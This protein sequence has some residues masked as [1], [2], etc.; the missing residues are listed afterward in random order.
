MPRNRRIEISGGVYHVITRGIERC[1]IFKDDHDHEE[2]VKRLEAALKDTGHKCYGWALMPNH[3]HLLIGTGV[4]PLSELMRKLLTGYAVYFN[5]KHKRSGHLYQNRYKS[6]LCQEESYLLE[7]V[8]YIHLNPLRAKLVTDMAGLGRYQWSGYTALVG[9]RSNAWQSTGEILERFGNKR[10]TAIR[11]FE[12]FV[13]DG[14]S[15]GKRTDLTGG[16]LRRSAGGWRGVYELKR[17]KERWQGDERVLGDGDFVAKVLST[18]EEKIERKERLKRDGWDIE[19]LKEEV[20]RIMKVSK[21]A[22][23]KRSRLSAISEAR[24]LLAWWANSELGI[25]RRTIADYLNIS[26]AAI[27]KNVNRG[28]QVA[29]EKNLKLQS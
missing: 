8:R 14:I 2:F 9:K 21:E 22:I 28:E 26:G 17:N 27:T 11:R 10:G 1:E 3:F 18:F 25:P 29:K 20:C 12:E 19:K 4:K 7:L 5:R 24:A 16:G 6:V 13:R 23:M 15:M